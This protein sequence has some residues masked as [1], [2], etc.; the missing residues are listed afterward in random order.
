MKITYARK[1]TE[2]VF[3]R[4]TN[5]VVI[6]RPKQ[7]VTVD[8]DL[9]PD[10]G[11]SRP[12]ARIWIE[13]GQYWIEDLG[14]INGTL[15]D[16]RPIIGKGK[17]QLKP[18]QSI[19]ISETTLS[20]E[21]AT[22]DDANRR[23]PSSPSDDTQSAQPRAVRLDIR[24]TIDASAPAFTAAGKDPDA[25]RRLALLYELPLQFGVDG[26]L[27][28]V[29]QTITERVVEV[30]PNA[31]RGA[32]LVR[33][34]TTGELLPK[35]SV[36]LGQPA[37]SETLVKRAM[38]ERRGFVWHRGPDLTASQGEYHIEA[39]MYVPL[40]WKDEVLGVVCVDNQQ[41]GPAF[42]EDDLRLLA[43][44]AHH[45][46]MAAVQNR[47]Q[48]DLRR[49]AA[50][51]GRLMTN[52]SP[53]IREQLLSRARHG[54][55]RLGGEKSEVAILMSDIR[56]F[57]QLT[58][59]ME[60]DDVVDLLNDYLSAL[61]EIIFKFDGT[62]DKFGGDSIL[63][64]FGSP[65]PDPQMYEK[66]VR[67]AIAMQAAMGQ[68]SERRLAHRQ[69]PCTIG[70][71]VHCGEVLHGFIGSKERMEFTIIGSPVNQTARYAAG[72]AGNEILISRDLW[73]R[74]YRLVDSEPVTIETKHEGNFQAFRIKGHKTGKL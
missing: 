49:N 9:T 62:V 71:G 61:V 64:V 31:M 33:D 23:A 60:T 17:V 56:G 52:F 74:T 4:D 48:E 72:A 53:K 28:A 65:E 54:R 26:G 6:G 16:G 73:Q 41:G 29:F 47:L 39:G 20:L 45:A 43:A 24:E 69:V 2:S 55:L 68:V 5:Q 42:N 34:R 67:A 63:A 51:L 27:D 18:G 35:G 37:V 38:Q 12:H 40:M 10:Q 58:A 44:V 25:T 30:I 11:A 1:G 50:L 57:T 3:D 14:S 46:A 36:P 7:G 59:G 22:E 15:V 13:G 19:H 70:I 21:A 32:L 66:A 8:L